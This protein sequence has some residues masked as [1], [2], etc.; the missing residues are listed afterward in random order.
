MSFIDFQ[1]KSWMSL[2]QLRVLLP[3]SELVH[4]GCDHPQG[5]VDDR[6]RVMLVRKGVGWKYIVPVEVG[7]EEFLA[8]VFE[9]LYLVFFSHYKQIIGQLLVKAYLS[10]VQ[11]VDKSTKGVVGHI[12]DLDGAALT[13][14][15]LILKHGFEHWRTAHLIS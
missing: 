11:V 7:H 8:V 6:L 14:F 13:F 9:M 3:G 1:Y 5:H 15:H 4:V 2:L 12:A 10:C